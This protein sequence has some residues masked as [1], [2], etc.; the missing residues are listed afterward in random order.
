M[1]NVDYTADGTFAYLHLSRTNVPSFDYTG[2][3][4]LDNFQLDVK[5]PDESLGQ[6]KT[7]FGEPSSSDEPMQENNDC[8]RNNVVIAMTSSIKIK[9]ADALMQELCALVRSADEPDDD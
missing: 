6:P 1:W 4:S 9:L 2:L 3:N 8:E 7:K 5:L